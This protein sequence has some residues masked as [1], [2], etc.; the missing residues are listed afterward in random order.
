MVKQLRCP[1]SGSP[2]C[3]LCDGHGVYSYEPGPRGWMPFI[4]PTCEG[5]GYLEKSGEPAQDC[6]T[7]HR[8]RNIDPADIPVGMIGKIR[9]MFFGG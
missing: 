7:C 1:C 8:A 9:K 4:C 3:K 2:A 5:K 6:P